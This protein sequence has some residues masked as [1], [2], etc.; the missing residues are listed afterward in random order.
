LLEGV[1]HRDVQLVTNNAQTQADAAVAL[2]QPHVKRADAIYV[3]RGT[4]THNGPANGGEEYIA[5]NLGAKVLAATDKASRWT[6]DIRI[7]RR[8]V[9]FTHHIGCGSINTKLSAL[10]RRLTI[11]TLERAAAGYP[12]PDIWI[13]GHCHTFGLGHTTLGAAMTCP[14]WKMTDEHTHKVV[15]AVLPQ[16]GGALIRFDP[17]GQYQ[18]FPRVYQPTPAQSGMTEEAF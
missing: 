2:I 14:S 10:Q 5:R 8:L 4:S 16:L 9:N 7:N 1:H 13:S 12:R 3:V 6:L 11:G 18:I 17:D 15:P